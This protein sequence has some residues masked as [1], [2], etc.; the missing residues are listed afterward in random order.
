MTKIEELRKKND[1]P[2]YDYRDERFKKYCSII[3][4]LD[5]EDII[6]YMNENTPIPEEG[7][8]YVPS[9]SE[10]EKFPIIE[11][12]RKVCFGGLDIQA[13]Y[14]N[15]RNS[16]FNG[17]EYHKGSEVNIACSDLVLILG[18]RSDISDELTYSV[19][20]PEVFF[21]EKGTVYE[22]YGTTLHLSPLRVCE[23]G[24][25]DVII[26]PR[27]TN[28][29]LSEEEKAARQEAIKKGDKEARLLL[30]KQ[31]WVISHPEREPL[32]KQGA[33]PGVTGPNKELF[34]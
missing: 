4:F 19:E 10:L 30:L 23:E 31:K 26:L 8:I 25:R 2:I 22:M 17:F 5:P 7:N 34:Y 24:F 28:T 18:Q 15:G 27:G 12:I 20:Q 29:P 9:V 14:C 3:G 13:G 32:I 6:S 33:H 16:T 21:I 11:E 1:F